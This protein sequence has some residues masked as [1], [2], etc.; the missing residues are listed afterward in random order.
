MQRS[1]WRTIVAA[2][3]V[4][5][6]RSVLAGVESQ[7]LGR[8]SR[9]FAAEDSAKEAATVDEAIK[10]LDLRTFLL[11]E[12][13]VVEDVRTVAAVNYEAKADP[14][15]TFQAQQQQFVKLGWK[16]LPGSMAEVA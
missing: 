9:H 15:K 13:A 5:C 14:K 1:N 10:V 3:L 2:G 7:L 12:G 11:P 16:E 4:T 8:H 6:G